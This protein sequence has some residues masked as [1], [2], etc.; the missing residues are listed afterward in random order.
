MEDRARLA[1]RSLPI[2]AAG[3]ATVL[4]IDFYGVPVLL[5]LSAVL[6]V[7]LAFRW[8]AVAAVV[9]IGSAVMFVLVSVQLTRCDPNI[10]DC[11]LSTGIVVIGAWLAALAV[12]GALAAVLISRRSEVA[13]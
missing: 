3:I 8:A 6:A 4:L 5:V 10:Q 9:A 13:R 2:V 7:A 12:T 1:V 11:S